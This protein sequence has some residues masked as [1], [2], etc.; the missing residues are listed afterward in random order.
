MYAEAGGE[1]TLQVRGMISGQTLRLE[2]RAMNRGQRTLFLFNILHDEMTEAGAFPLFD[3]AYVESTGD[4]VVISRKLFPVP[5]MTFVERRN[6]P[7][8]T[9]LVPG[10][11][12]QESL[13]LSLPLK[14]TDPYREFDSTELVQW[15]EQ[16]VFFELGYFV[17]AEGTEQLAKSFPTDAGARPGFDVFTESSQ[18]LQRAG[19]LGTVPIVLAAPTA[20][21][22]E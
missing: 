9:R 4:A 20:A 10:A 14:P 7:F 21:A 15:S 2:Y 17:G 8:V 11:T 12:I 5:P 3:G 6:I 16:P 1:L 22:A 19:P 13:V 18:I